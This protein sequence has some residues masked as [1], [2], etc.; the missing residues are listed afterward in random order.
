[1]Q[2]KSSITKRIQRE[3]LRRTD[4]ILQ[5]ALKVMLAKSYT[6]ATMDDIAAEAGIT[7]PTI[8]QYFKTKDDLVVALVEPI[9][10]TLAEKL[11]AIKTDL[12]SGNYKSGKQIVHD[13]YNVYYDTF[14]TDPNLFK[15]FN[16][17]MQMGI[18]KGQNS[19]AI[20]KIRDLG[21]KCFVAGHTIAST[22][23]SKGFFKDVDVHNTTEFVWGSF[24]GI[25]QIEQ[26]KW[27]EEGISPYL[28]P[29]LKYGEKLLITA[30]VKK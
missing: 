4:E 20:K 2:R 24:W 3:K 1:M 25:A 10:L 19:T 26:N 28:K 30:L 23:V 7:K 22:A 13:V 11:N 18:K 6:G 9:I 29:V 14:E 21:K 27:G 16:I 17:F 5:A 8:Y 15:L 12:D